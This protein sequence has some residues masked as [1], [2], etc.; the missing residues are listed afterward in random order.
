M[1]EEHPQPLQPFSE[2]QNEVR[3]LF[4]E[5]IHQPW[6]AR[7]P[8]AA[9]GWQP[10]CDM[11]ETEAAIV[12]EVE[13]PGVERKDVRIEVEGDVLCI[14]GERQATAEHRERQYY[15]ME[16]SYG[17]FERQLPL[18][19]SVDREAIRAQ[20]QE[21]ILTITLPKKRTASE[22]PPQRHERSHD[23]RATGNLP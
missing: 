11:A 5:L 12:V 23:E 14:S 21:G 13:L 20:F 1:A 8:S 15:R 9:T 17:R 18:P 3:R 22:V 16:R 7:S 19:A 4:Q 6:E 2:V 10:C